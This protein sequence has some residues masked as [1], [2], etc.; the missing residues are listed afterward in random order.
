MNCPKCNQSLDDGI[1]FCPYDGTPL[2]DTAS[3]ISTPTPTAAARPASKELEL[4][5]TVGGR[6]RL[7]ALRG[8]GGMAKVYRATDVTLDRVV[9]VKLI[10]PELRAESEFDARFQRE[11]RIASALADPHI[12]VVH[13]YGLDPTH[14]PFLVME[15]LEGQSLRERLAASGPMPLKPALQLAGGVFLALIHAHSKGIVHRDIKPDNIFLLNVSGV[16]LHVRVLDFGIARI[17]RAEDG[18]SGNTITNAGSVLGT[19]RYMSPE[20]LAGHPVD[21]R[22]DLYSAALVLFE[23]LTG[24]MPYASGK[25]LTELVPEAGPGLVD[26]LERCL[27]PAPADRPPTAVEVYLRLQD[28]GKASGILLLPPGAMDKLVAA[29]Q[30]DQETKVWEPGPSRRGWLYAAGALAALV[31]AVLGWWLTT[32]PPPAG[33]P[34]SLL[35]AKIGQTQAETRVAFTQIDPG[36]PWKRKAGASLGGV[37]KP[38]DLKGDASAALTRS[39]ADGATHGVFLD[40]RLAALV[41]AATSAATARGVRVGSTVG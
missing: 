19:P 25:R 5:V 20:Q 16:K 34:E 8:G 38:G 9:A 39:T 12:V 7:D 4:P 6:Y 31:L 13:D 29:R 11:A 27:R 37:L 41:T 22:S 30:A 24:Q 33:G 14:G 1:R 40:E 18:T 10:N 28:L 21:A 17:Y 32:G 2:L 15:F 3:T 35:G 26:L 36:D 23:A